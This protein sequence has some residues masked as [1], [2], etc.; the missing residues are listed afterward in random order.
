MDIENSVS[1]DLLSTFVD[2][3]N[4]FDCHLTDVESF[5]SFMLSGS[6]N[7]VNTYKVCDI[8]ER[9]TNTINVGIQRSKYD[10]EMP[11][12]HTAHQP[13]TP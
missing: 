8:V 6:S 11:Q 9:S 5:W 4:V 1:N 3:I 7:F 10:R 12:S 13:T 2:S